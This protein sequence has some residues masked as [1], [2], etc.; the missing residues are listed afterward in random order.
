MLQ[1]PELGLLKV[2]AAGYDPV[3]AV[4][5]HGRKRYFG[6]ITMPTSTVL[7]LYLELEGFQFNNIT[8]RT[9]DGPGAF[10][11]PLKD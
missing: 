3:A 4:P 1:D 10:W 7:D 9:P 2:A 5:M 11:D 6:K 8:K